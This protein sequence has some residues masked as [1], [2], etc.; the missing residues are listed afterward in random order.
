MANLQELQQRRAAYVA[1][2]LRIIEGAQEYEISDGAARRR[3]TRAD[4]AEIRAA[5]KALD[6]EIA[7]AQPGARRVFRFVPGCR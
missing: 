7:A 5:I 6:A 3:L 4:L 2:E 1:A